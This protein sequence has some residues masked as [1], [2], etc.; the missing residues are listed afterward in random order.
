M[1]DLILAIAEAWDAEAR[2]AD[3]GCR[4]TQ[5]DRGADTL[6]CPLH[7]EEDEEWRQSIW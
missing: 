3:D 6:G 2:A 5:T 1:T 7:D 4:C